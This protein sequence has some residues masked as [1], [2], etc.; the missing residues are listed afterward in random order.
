MTYA[1]TGRQA[2][3]CSILFAL[4]VKNFLSLTRFRNQF[5]RLFSIS[6]ER[7][8]ALLFMLLQTSPC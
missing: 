7:E 1:C 3:S 5:F 2:H 8:G 6:I 4:A